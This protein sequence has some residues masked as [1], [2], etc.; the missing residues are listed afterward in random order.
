MLSGWAPIFQGPGL[1]GH[2]LPVPLD[3][4]TGARLHTGRL[5]LRLM[6]FLCQSH[7]PSEPRVP[8]PWM[9]SADPVL[10]TQ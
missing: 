8:G 4:D 3:L 2:R 6:S 5:P 7:L 10:S 1:Q 9:S